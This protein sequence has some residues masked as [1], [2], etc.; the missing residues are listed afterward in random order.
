M[1]DEAQNKKGMLMGQ[2]L[3]TVYIHRSQQ[4]Q[5]EGFL[6]TASKHKGQEA[7]KTHRK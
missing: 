1:K 3:L 6:S 4:S 7:V 5:Y 2:I